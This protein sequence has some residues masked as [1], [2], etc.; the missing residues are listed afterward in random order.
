MMAVL[1][2]KH[3]CTVTFYFHKL[4]NF[5]YNKYFYKRTNFKHTSLF[6]SISIITF[7]A[8]LFVFCITY[9]KQMALKKVL[10]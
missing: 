8:Y 4:N 9:Y 2:K 6:Y 7:L 1:V 10:K 3:V 5:N